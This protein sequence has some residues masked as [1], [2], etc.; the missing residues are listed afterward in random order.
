MTFEKSEF[1]DTFQH[2]G[3]WWLPDLPEHRVHGTLTHTESETTLELFGSLRD[4]DI[5]TTGRVTIPKPTTVIYGHLEGEGPCTL[6]RNSRG[7]VRMPLGGKASS[8]SW[9]SRML[10][11]GIHL[12]D[13]ASAEFCDWTVAFTGLEEWVG[14]SPFQQEESPEGEATL[15]R[16]VRYVQP[17]TIAVSIPSA[18]MN[19]DLEFG[20]SIT[21]NMYRSLTLSRTPYLVLRPRSPRQLE[22]FYATLRD[23]QNFLLFCIGQPAYPKSIVAHI[24]AKEQET[25]NKG[26]EGKKPPKETSVRVYYHYQHYREQRALSPAQM[27]L[28]LPSI[29]HMLSEMLNHWF[30][31]GEKLRDVYGLFFSTIYNAELYTQSVFLSL[32][33]AVET[34]SRAVHEAIYVA[35]TDYEQ[36]SKALG[37]AIPRDTPA[38]LKT[39]LKSRIKYG[40]EYSLRKRLKEILSSLE[41]ETV[42]LIT[43]DPNRFGNRIVDT[44]NYLTHYSEELRGNAISG[45]DL[46]IANYRLKLLLTILLCKELGIIE[47]SV[48]EM[49]MTNP[50]WLQLIHLHL[51]NGS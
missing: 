25:E 40:N 24:P 30:S 12:P 28:P 47:S 50:D 34:Y 6:F 27:P 26:H 22:W 17:E 11:I 44:R 23:V 18:D 4:E 3:V 45:T 31:K 41:A 39:S 10:F 35:P 9:S 5:E 48:R 2:K 38:D 7:S 49:L 29:C 8:S 16:T 19:L 20:L 42:G 32:T 46:Q 33:Q 51:R 13:P 14:T 43:N 36:I 21:G 1:F 15:T 37:E